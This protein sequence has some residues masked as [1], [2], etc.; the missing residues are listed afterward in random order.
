MIP[1]HLL[2]GL[3]PDERIAVLTRAGGLLFHVHPASARPDAI[4]AYAARE[5]ARVLATHL[6][7]ADAIQALVASREG[8]VGGEG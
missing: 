7:D 8:D 6:A 4:E 5:G 3:G 2:T 1:T